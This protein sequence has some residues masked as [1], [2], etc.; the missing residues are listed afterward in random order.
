MANYIDKI[1]I[2]QHNVLRWTFNRRNE[3]SN[4]YIKE[5]P[6]IILLNSTGVRDDAKIKL[7]GYNVHQ[8]NESGENHSG[9]AIAIKRN[10][11]YMIMDDWQGDILAVRVETSK[12]PIIIATTYLPPRRHFI[13]EAQ[14]RSLLNHREPTY[15]LGDLNARHR[16]IGY[17]SNNPTGDFIANLISRNLCTHMGP[18]FNTLTWVSGVG[19]PD[20]LLGNQRAPLLHHALREGDLTS[21][22]HLPVVVTLSTKPIIVLTKNNLNLKKTNWDTFQT[23]IAERM[24]QQQQSLTRTQTTN[25]DKTKID[26]ELST[27]MVNIQE[28]LEK[29]TP[30]QAFKQLPT[31]KE[32]DLLKLAEEKYRNMRLNNPIWTRQNITEMRILQNIII[33][34]SIRL[35]QEFWTNKIKTMENIYNDSAKFWK[36]VRKVK[37]SSNETTTY[38]IY[39][40]SNNRKVHRIEEQLDLYHGYWQGVFQISPEENRT[41]DQ[42]N[43]RRVEMSLNEEPDRYL[44]YDYVNLDRLAAD[45]Y[46]TKPVT[47][48]N[49]KSIIRAFKN[50]A[51][52]RS[53]INKMILLKLPEIAYDNLTQILNWTLSMGY[54]PIILKEGIIVLILK[55][56]KNPRM[57]SSYRP[58]TL[59]EVPGKILE[60]IINN[61]LTRFQEENNNYHQHQFGFRKGKGTDIAIAKLYETIT[62]NQRERGQ[63]N[64]VAR[65]IEKA[66][67]KI[68]H[69]GLKFKIATYNLPAIFEKILC[70]FLDDRTARIR[71]KDHLSEVID[72]KSGVPQGSILSPNLFISYTS[73]MPPAQDDSTEIIFADDVTQIVQYM[74]PSKKMLALKTQR[75]IERI[76]EYE[77]LWKIKTSKNKF[78]ILSISKLKPEEITIENRIVPFANEISILGLKITRTGL[79]RHIND[80][81]R[82][83]KTE[84]SKL[85]RFSALSPK[86]KTHM[87]KTLIR[88]VMEYPAV[89]LCSIAQTNQMKMQRLQNKAIKFS[90]RNDDEEL[91][92]QQAH[93]KYK[94][95]AINVRMA[96]RGNK[97]WEKF[98]IIDPTLTERSMNENEN[99]EG[100]DHYWWR[101]IAGGIGDDEPDPI[102]T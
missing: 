53:G 54:F 43:E 96:K 20:I 5:D 41:F 45:N 73:D 58:I 72:L 90:I 9:I 59:L 56:G 71:Y 44:P 67:D 64:I 89:P 42:Q 11:K 70:S 69:R 60:R 86:I 25:I 101:R 74:G 99:L 88:P 12:G 51:P 38:L 100:K 62:L 32:S 26:E 4:Y 28:E 83:A 94:M 13:P 2:I 81:I 84:L 98:C 21:S 102:Y 85:K 78:K 34:E 49:I 19:R 6:E 77:K 35:N 29:S 75:A 47:S 80:R 97:I 82:M 15:I 18:D 7:F 92:V 91:T 95:D 14:I 16:C 24:L 17:T 40:S 23:S 79:G 31:Y 76:N 52:G 8:R 65:D 1:K 87:Y 30:R 33:E 66:F 63:C 36:E 39:E 3:L 37:G 10:I 68:W 93:E 57:V 55:P 61:R 50:K 46:L 48:S 27:W 22:D